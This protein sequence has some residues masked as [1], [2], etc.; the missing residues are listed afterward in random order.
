MFKKLIQFSL[1]ILIGLQIYNYFSLKKQ[2]PNWVVETLEKNKCSD[3]ETIGMDLPYSVLFNTETIGTVYLTHKK[4]SHTSV[5][6]DYI[7]TTVPLFKGLDG[8]GVYTLTS[9]Q[10]KKNFLHCWGGLF[11]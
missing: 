3:Y 9:E 4:Y 7:D 5:K 10:I 1:V 2:I 8:E 11:Q 6:V